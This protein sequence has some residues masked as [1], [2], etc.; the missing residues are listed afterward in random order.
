MAI[1]RMNNRGTEL[2]T[3]HQFRERH[4]TF[5][6]GVFQNQIQYQTEREA[7]LFQ[8]VSFPRLECI[9]VF[10]E[11]YKFPRT[12]LPERLA[13]AIPK[14]RSEP[15]LQHNSSRLTKTKFASLSTELACLLRRCLDADL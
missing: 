1:H 4:R 7:S 13:H 3:L 14:S 5:E 8:M 12:P 15:S 9:L 11:H 6:V 2:G 10:R